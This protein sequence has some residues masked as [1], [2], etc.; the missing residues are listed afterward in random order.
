[1]TADRRDA[2]WDSG[3]YGIW[4]IWGSRCQVSTPARGV[5]VA[6]CSLLISPFQLISSSF[7]SSKHVSS[8]MLQF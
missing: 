5:I 6:R 7:S 2:S 3:S 4:D 8:L 1:M